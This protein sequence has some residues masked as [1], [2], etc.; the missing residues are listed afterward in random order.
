MVKFH[1]FTSLSNNYVQL[2]FPLSPKQVSSSCQLLTITIRIDITII[3]FFVNL[4]L[5]NDFFA[6]SPKQ[7]SSIWQLLTITT[8]TIY[9]YYY[10]LLL[11]LL[12]QQQCSIYF[13]SFSEAGQQPLATSNYYWSRTLNH[14][15]PIPAQATNIEIGI[16]TDLFTSFKL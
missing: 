8:I 9:F 4:F 15:T 14:S 11:L 5:S 7:V 1:I 10:V 13:F 6:L 12:P 16:F 2:F 3:I